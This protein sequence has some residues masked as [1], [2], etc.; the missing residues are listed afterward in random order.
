M[1]DDVQV[2]KT[3]SYWLRHR[4][5]AAQIDLDDAGWAPVD[6]VLKAFESALPG[7]DWDRLVEVVELNDKQRFEL[8]GDGQ[9]IRARQGH[10]VQIS[11]DWPVVQPPEVLFH[12]TIERALP[13]ILAEGL[14]PM[15]RHHVH[16]SSDAVT[17]NK[18]G[19]RRGAPV[20]LVI[21][22]SRM[23]DEGHAFR[24]TSNGVWLVRHVPPNFIDLD[25]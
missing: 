13:S 11:G 4:P 23:A 17:A 21:Q 2:S 22:S 14:K 1:A 20:V 25:T 12:G 6:A 19:A 15:R 9:R 18:V 7:V 5:D 8:S 10:S 24:L 16:L 3:L